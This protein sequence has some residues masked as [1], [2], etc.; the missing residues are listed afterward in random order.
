MTKTIRTLAIAIA[1]AIIAAPALAQQPQ[2]VDAKGAADVTTITAKI[3]AIDLANRVVTLKG[4]LG[5]TVS[6][7]VDD[8]VKNLAQV[9]VGDELVLK[10]TEAVSVALVKGGGGRSKT[11]T[12]APMATAPAGAKPGA[13]AAQ[14]TN[15]VARVDRIDPSGVVLLEGPN[16]RYVEVR[17]KDPGVLKDVKVGDDVEITYTEAIVVDVVAPKK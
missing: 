15:I 2:V 9:K 17:V 3:E 7:K 13:A 5:R 8:R 6:F 4:P 1:A 10:Y 16:S 12:T 14:Q 11:V